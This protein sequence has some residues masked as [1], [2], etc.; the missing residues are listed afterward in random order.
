MQD[1][2]S[3]KDRT[4]PIGMNDKYRP[5]DLPDGYCVDAKNCFLEERKIREATG[6]TMIANNTGEDKPILGLAAF[7]TSTVNQLLKFNDNSTGSAANLFYWTG[8]G[9]WTKVDSPSFTAGKE[10]E[11]E[12]AAGNAYITNGTD[13]PKKW[14]GTTL[15]DV[16]GFPVT[17]Y[18]KWFHNYMWAFG[19][20]HRLYFSN[21]G[22][23][24]TWGASDYI[25]ISP[26][27]GDIPTGLSTLKD[28]LIIAK[29]NRIWSFTGW[30]SSSFTVKDINE[31]IAGY[32]SVAN[33]F[34]NTGNDL[35]YLSYVGDIPHFRSLQR[36]RYATIVAGGII[37]DDIQNTMNSLSKTQLSKM[38]GF[39][40]GRKV[41]FFVPSG[42]SSYNDLILIYDT[43]TKGWVRQTGKYGAKVA[44]SDVTGQPI[45]YFGD[46]RNSKVY[47]LDTSNSNDG[48]SIDFQFISRR[49]MPDFKRKFKWKYLWMTGEA[50][51][52]V[53]VGVSTSPDG[54]NYVS[55]GNFNLKNPGSL[56]SFSFPAKL[57]VPDIVFKRFNLAYGPKHAMQLKLTKSNTG[58]RAVIR[59][60]EFLAQAKPLR[61]T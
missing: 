31:K 23:P 14:N 36:T 41:W 1:L 2:T 11:V 6:C 27:D 26:N 59:D 5:E 34:V 7:K 13:T 16:T 18:I 46:S 39:Y 12:V 42:S 58:A 43:T 19:T 15:T 21:L 56:F 20:N 9:N 8:S 61:P 49:Y 29:Q 10:I 54:F 28:E 45:I 51:G 37:S 17:P 55:Q 35:Y 32:G 47:K 22:D 52:D 44:I 38:T 40:D 48:A 4:F 53:D 30:T 25:D 3:I 33:C 24:E 57:G 60:W 50:V